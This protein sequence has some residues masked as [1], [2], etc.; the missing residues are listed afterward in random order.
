MPNIHT[1][2]TTISFTEYYTPSKIEKG[3]GQIKTCSYSDYPNP[4][5]NEVCEVDVRD[6]G[7]CNKDQFFNYHKN[8][9]C[10]FIKLNKIFGWVPEYYDD[11]YNLP[12]D[13]PQHLIDHIRSL[14]NTREVGATGND[15]SLFIVYS[16]LCLEEKRV[17]VLSR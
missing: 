17:G 9:P 14:N 15:Q 1:I 8:S 11:P 5:T 6:W 10:I 13:M 16:S 3:N 4:L 12:Q 7:E 2:I